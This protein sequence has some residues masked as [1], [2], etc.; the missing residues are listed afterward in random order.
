MSEND[1]QYVERVLR[2]IHQPED[3]HGH[4]ELAEIFERAAGAY[5]AH[6]EAVAEEFLMSDSM[7]RGTINPSDHADMVHLEC[8]NGGAIFSVGSIARCGSLSVK[9]SAYTESTVIRIVLR[10]FES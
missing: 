8:P 10:R 9:G 6:G 5:G 2:E 7:Q 3:R 1:L 4:D